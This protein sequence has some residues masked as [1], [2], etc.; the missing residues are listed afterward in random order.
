V[1]IVREADEDER[2]GANGGAMPDLS[3]NRPGGSVVKPTVCGGCGWTVEQDTLTG[4]WRNQHGDERCGVGFAHYPS[5]T[6]TV[7]V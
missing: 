4:E 6:V 7:K 5:P 2:D 1:W 3:G